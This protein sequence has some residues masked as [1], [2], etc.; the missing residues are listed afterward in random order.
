[1]S[2]LSF[3]KKLLTPSFSPSARGGLSVQERIYVRE[4]WAE[5][6]TLMKVGRPSAFKTAVLDADKLLDHVLKSLN[7]RGQ[8][9]GE[10]MKM[11]PRDDFDRDFF[12]DMWQAHKLRNEMV[13]NMD[14]NVMDFEART[15]IKKFEKTL[16]D[17]GAM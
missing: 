4:K 17:L 13:H 15:A 14:Y 8:T 9:M 11:I 1:M 10:R 12:N 6:E 7:Y 5:I 3:L 16:Q 2:F